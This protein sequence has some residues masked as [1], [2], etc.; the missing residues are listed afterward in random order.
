MQ[1]EKL[2][3]G[4]PIQEEYHKWEKDK[5]KIRSNWTRISVR[6][7]ASYQEMGIEW[8][9]QSSARDLG[10][11]RKKL[12][13][14]AMQFSLQTKKTVRGCWEWAPTGAVLRRSIQGGSAG[15]NKYSCEGLPSS[16]EAPNLAARTSIQLSDAFCPCLQAGFGPQQPSPQSLSMHPLLREQGLRQEDRWEQPQLITCLT[17]ASRRWFV[18]IQQIIIFERMKRE[19]GHQLKVL[20]MNEDEKKVLGWEVFV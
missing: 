15:E 5:K 7:L 16:F 3:H 6:E 8:C 10:G 4:K 2:Y 20:L 19:E 18:G 1:W 14:M 17:N 9:V 12:Q 11:G 13:G